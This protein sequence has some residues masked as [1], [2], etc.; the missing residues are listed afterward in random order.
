MLTIFSV[1]IYDCRSGSGSGSRGGRGQAEL[2]AVAGAAPVAAAGG[3]RCYAVRR[4]GYTDST[5]LDTTAV[6]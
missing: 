2:D 5:R 3:V 4:G 6:V 1:H